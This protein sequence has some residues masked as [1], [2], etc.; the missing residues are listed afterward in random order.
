MK[1]VLKESCRLGWCRENVIIE[2]GGVMDKYVQE[3][4]RLRQ[5]GPGYE[6]E[7]PCPGSRELTRR[8][9]VGTDWKKTLD[10]WNL[11]RALKKGTWSEIRVERKE[12]R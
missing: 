4:W 9:L 12:R 5:D 6:R 7:R 2:T 3:L 1:P 10:G 11:R 8:A